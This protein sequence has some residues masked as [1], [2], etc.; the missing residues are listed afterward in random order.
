MGTGFRGRGGGKKE[1][2]DKLI[3]S[4]DSFSSPPIIPRIPGIDLPYIQ[5]AKIFQDASKALEQ[6]K[7]DKSIAKVTIVGADYIG[8]ELAEAYQRVGKEITLI[9]A[10]D[11]ILGTH[12]DR[13]FSDVMAARLREHGIKLALNE[14]VERFEGTD[15]VTAVVT[16]KGSYQTDL[17]IMCIGFRPNCSLAGKDLTIFRNGAILVDKHQRTSLPDVYAVGDCATVY[18]NSVQTTSYI[19][20]V[21]NAVRSG[22]IAGMNVAGRSVESLGV[23]GFSALCLYGLRMVCT[24][25]T[26][27]TAAQNGILA[28]MTEFKGQ[29]KPAFMDEAVPNHT[30][31]IRIV[32]RKDNHQVI[33]AQ[34]M[35]EYDMSATIHMFSLDI[36]EKMTIERI[37]LCDF[38]FMPHFN[39]PYNYTAMATLKAL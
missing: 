18:D 21:T 24:G 39:Q 5:R 22:L 36:Q 27:E 14:K 20:L 28:Q 32:Y 9:D 16:D 38:F 15:R 30:I 11:R 8:A 25:Q 31:R 4:T 29:Q 10:L 3:L 23:Q 1:S 7:K 19:A 2:Y 37:A 35:G 13:D 17:V 34:L 12:F 6:I 26:V 33:G